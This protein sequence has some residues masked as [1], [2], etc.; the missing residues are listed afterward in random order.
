[1]RKGDALEAPQSKKQKIYDGMTLLSI[2]VHQ[3]QMD[4]FFFFLN[5]GSG[6]PFMHFI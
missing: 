6:F 5:S 2:L 4:F 1:M 3:S